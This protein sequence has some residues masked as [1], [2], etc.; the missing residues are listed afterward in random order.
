[1]AEYLNDFIDFFGLSTFFDGTT[2]TVQ[3]ALGISIVAFVGAI[4]TI[5]GVR[6]VFELIKI[7]TDWGRFR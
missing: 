1:M 4:F 7:V 3:N 5:L 6:C 2:L